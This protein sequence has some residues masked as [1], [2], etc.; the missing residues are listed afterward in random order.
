MSALVFGQ[1][2]AAPMTIDDASFIDTSFPDF[3]PL[4]RQLGAAI[5]AA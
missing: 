5:G 3:V 2:T 4:M 1:V